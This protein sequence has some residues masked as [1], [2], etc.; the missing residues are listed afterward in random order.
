MRSLIYGRQ[1]PYYMIVMLCMGGSLLVFL[2]I[3]VIFAWRAIGP[4]F[5]PVRVPAIFW[6]SSMLSLTG[7]FLLRE[8]AYSLRAEKYNAYK[9][10]I[11]SAG[12]IGFLFAVCQVQG[13]AQMRSEGILLDNSISGSFIYLLSGL[14]LAHILAGLTALAFIYHDARRNNTY[15]DGFIQSLNPAKNTRFRLTVIY[16]HF[17]NFLWLG[18]FMLFLVQQLKGHPVLSQT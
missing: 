14:H 7:S 12:I 10:L 3:S 13:W 9:N 1:N 16:W 5:A 6:V 15:V 4:G 18:L 2:I 8:S 17:V 11:G